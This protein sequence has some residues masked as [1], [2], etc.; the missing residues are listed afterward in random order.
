MTYGLSAVAYLLLSF[1]LCWVASSSTASS[2]PARA[3]IGS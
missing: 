2:T 3:S 1:V